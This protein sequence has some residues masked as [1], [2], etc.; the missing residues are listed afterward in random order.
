MAEFEQERKRHLRDAGGA[1][2]GHVRDHNA[3]LTRRRDI[4]DVVAGRGHANVTELRQPLHVP[5][6]DFHFVGEQ[7][8]GGRG[9][10]QEFGIRR[11]LVNLALAQGAP[12]VPAQVAGIERV[13]VDDDDL[14]AQYFATALPA[15][16]PSAPAISCAL[17]SIMPASL[18]MAMNWKPSAMRRFACAA[19][20]T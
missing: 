12:V 20:S 4:D 14:H 1:V 2:G 7:N 18:V 19:S 5:V 8:F 15:P 13:T 16:S 9:A 10:R 11:A 17:E 3:A 6:A